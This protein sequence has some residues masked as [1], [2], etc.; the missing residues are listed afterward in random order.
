MEQTKSGCITAQS[1]GSEAFTALAIHRKTTAVSRV[2]A[3]EANKEHVFLQEVL[4]WCVHSEMLREVAYACELESI[5]RKS[6]VDCGGAR[7]IISLYST[8]RK[9]F[10]CK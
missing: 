6:S 5:D 1:T 3:A 4:C 10:P 9:H 7:Q 2:F 8:A